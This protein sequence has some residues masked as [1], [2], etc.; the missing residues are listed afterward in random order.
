MN[1]MQNKVFY[2]YLVSLAAAMGGL[3]FGFD[4]AIISGTVPFIQKYFALN[5][6]ALGWGVSSLLAGCILG[7]LLAGKISDCL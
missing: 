5:D 6:L 2:K 3:M 7:A 1:A 4:I